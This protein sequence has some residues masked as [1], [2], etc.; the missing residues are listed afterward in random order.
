[1]VKETRIVFE[2]SDLLAFRIVC[3]ECGGDVVHSFNIEFPNAF[4]R[5]P[6]CGHM[7]QVGQ[8]NRL[9]EAIRSIRHTHG[10]AGLRLELDGETVIQSDPG[11]L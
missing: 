3:E 2:V 8:A 7:W 10:L 9:I 11:K 5:C 6:W 4:S 1:M